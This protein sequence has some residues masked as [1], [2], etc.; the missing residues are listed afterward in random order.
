MWSNVADCCKLWSKRGHEMRLQSERFT[1][2]TPAITS[3]KWASSAMCWV[4]AIRENRTSGLISP[5][6]NP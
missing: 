1:F 6:R 3:L 4:M 5:D 2:G